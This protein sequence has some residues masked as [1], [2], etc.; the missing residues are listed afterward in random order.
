MQQKRGGRQSQRMCPLRRLQRKGHR[1]HRKERE[2]Q[3]QYQKGAKKVVVVVVVAVVMVVRR[4]A[5]RQGHRLEGVSHLPTQ[6][7]VA[8]RQRQQQEEA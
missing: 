4:V 3:N 7:E 8:Q 1:G 6:A 5:E 2:Q